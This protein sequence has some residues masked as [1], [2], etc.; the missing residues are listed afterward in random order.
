MR[1]GFRGL[2]TGPIGAPENMGLPLM[3]I[4]ADQY[5]ENLMRRQ[6]EE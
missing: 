6:L 4:S 1:H 5:R 3:G 2:W